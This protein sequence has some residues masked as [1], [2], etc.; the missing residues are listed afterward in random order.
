MAVNVLRKSSTNPEVQ[1]ISKGLI[2]SWKKLLTGACQANMLCQHYLVLVCLSFIVYI[3]I[4]ISFIVSDKESS[5]EGGSSKMDS[6]SDKAPTKSKPE[7]ADKE[8]KVENKFVPPTNN[9]VRQKCR[10]MIKNSLMS[11]E[12][13]DCKGTLG[14]S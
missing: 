10:D 2:K 5:K 3:C 11:T 9:D 4:Q 6:E 13:E 12:I 7:N 1:T 8:E 14:S